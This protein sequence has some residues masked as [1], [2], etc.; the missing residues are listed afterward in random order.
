MTGWVLWVII[1]CGFG[2]GEMLTTGFFLAPFAVGAGLAAAIAVEYG[3]SFFSPATA[4]LLTNKY[5]QRVALA[6]AGVPGGVR[7][8]QEF[9]DARVVPPGL[10]LAVGRV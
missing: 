8:A 3:L 1:A 2:I 7:G 4:E 10:A 5:E 9:Q 6:R